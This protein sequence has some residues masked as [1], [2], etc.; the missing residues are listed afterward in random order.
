MQL[1][2]AL[3]RNHRRKKGT[4][5]D[6]PARA[7][8]RGIFTFLIVNFCWVSGRGGNENSPTGDVP[9]AII[10]KALSSSRL[11][12]RRAARAVDHG[13]EALQTAGIRY[14][15]CWSWS[16]GD[17]GRLLSRGGWSCPSPIHHTCLA[18]RRAGAC[19]LRGI[20]SALGP[21][22]STFRR[23]GRDGRPFPRTLVY[24][25]GEPPQ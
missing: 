20:C 7:G 4:A 22:A 6:R 25:F 3:A 11:W 10:I 16:R 1:H 12:R 2:Q 17:L 15:R 13:V 14:T 19:G 23:G 21:C 9:R 24:F 5:L 18:R 8:G